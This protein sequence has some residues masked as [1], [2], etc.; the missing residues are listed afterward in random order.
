[1]NMWPVLES[2]LKII[3]PLLVIGVGVLVIWRIG[4]KV[5]H[6]AQLELEGWRQ[7]DLQRCAG[8]GESGGITYIV[9]PDNSHNHLVRCSKCGDE[10]ERYYHDV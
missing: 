8:C 7:R 9:D 2:V 10:R 5:G 1:M 3:G 4:R 6:D